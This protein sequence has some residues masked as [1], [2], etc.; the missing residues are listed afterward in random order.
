MGRASRSG[1]SEGTHGCEIEVTLTAARL[2]V[3]STS[4][5]VAV[6]VRKPALGWILQ[7]RSR[8]DRQTAYEII[9]A[10]RPALLRHDRADVW[11]SG[12]VESDVSSCGVPYQPCMST[13]EGRKQAV[14]PVLVVA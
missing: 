4:D 2:V 11:K 1:S 5:P 13:V 7:G 6:D 10:S 8:S 12:R 3:E 14:S 9:V